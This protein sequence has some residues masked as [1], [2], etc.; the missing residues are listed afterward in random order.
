MLHSR[1]RW[2]LRR[3]ELKKLFNLSLPLIL[4]QLAQSSMGFVD[5]IVAGR[6]SAIDL[7]A[8]AVGSS[9]WF[10]L[11]LLLLGILSAL[12]PTISQAHGAGHHHMIRHTTPQGVYLGAIAGLLITIIL[13]HSSF[14][15]PWLKADPALI[16][17][18]EGYLYG[19]S[20]GFPAI[21]VCFA[22]R[23]CSEGLSLT[24]PSMV[25]SF[26]GLIVNIIANYILVFGKC[27]FTAMG[28]VGCG[29][30]SAIAMW[31]M[32]LG[33]IV[34]FWRGHIYRNLD[35]LR[36]I[37]PWCWR[38]QKQLLKLGLPIGGGLFIEC[39]IFAIIALLLARFGAQSVAAHQIA[40]NFTS[41]IFM[42]P[43]SIGT[44][45]SVRVGYTI[46]RQRKNQLLR[47]TRCGI[48]SAITLALISCSV[49]LLFPLQCVSIYSNDP[50]LLTAAAALLFFAAI[51]QVPDAIQV[52]SA[53]ALRG[54]K[55]TRTPMLI[56][57]IAYW[58]I[59]L[60]IGCYLGL[61]LNWGARGF[62]IGLICGL[63]SAAIMLLLRLHHILHRLA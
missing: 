8:V 61:F 16:P 32:M 27:G 63:T 13:Q 26:F 5:T 36:I 44:A 4:A 14:I 37:N 42:I 24:R 9:V 40:L 1:R 31:A 2:L 3:I 28:G 54:C 47:A 11:L 22:L 35:M 51:Y 60:P 45:I 34:V 38:T 19:V 33:M 41:M 23:Y 49:I 56:Q 52:S 57:T 10:P 17:L 21:G 29:P 15:L 53:G 30:A 25:V 48:T 7:A 20:W 12:T 39:S 62:W 18:I 43:L 50:Q 59:G 6:V 46:G 55:D 58:A